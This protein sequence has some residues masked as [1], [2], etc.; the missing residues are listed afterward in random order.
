MMRT[1]KQYRDH[2]HEKW[3]THCTGCGLCC[4]EKTVIGHDVI[5]DLNAWC[6]HYDPE[7][8]TCK[9]YAQRFSAQIRCR[10]VNHF[11]AMFA[12]YLPPTCG[13]VQWAKSHYLR[14]APYRR[15]HYVKDE[16]E[17]DSDEPAVSDR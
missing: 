14:F 1:F 17:S 6:E 15:I 13:Y 9:V 10:S 3:E 7:T 11:R 2:R 4:H 8:H 12:V 5:Y 16:S